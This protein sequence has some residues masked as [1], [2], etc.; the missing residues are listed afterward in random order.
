MGNRVFTVANA[1]AANRPTNFTSSLPTPSITYLGQMYILQQDNLPDETFICL[2]AADGS[3]SWKS[4][5]M[6]DF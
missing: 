3:Y 6:G 2:K 5:A 1:A 4:I